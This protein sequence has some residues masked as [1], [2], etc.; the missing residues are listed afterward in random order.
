M[1]WCH[2]GNILLR[3]LFSHDYH[4]YMSV[5]MPQIGYDPLFCRR[6]LSNE[7]AT[8]TLQ[9]QLL[10]IVLSEFVSFPKEDVKQTSSFAGSD[11][12]RVAKLQKQE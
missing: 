4:E 5:W 3:H 9:P 11:R 6:E 1:H 10:L 12:M 8:S 7:L 2:G